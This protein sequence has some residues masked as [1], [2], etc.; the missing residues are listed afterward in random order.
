MASFPI[1][2]LH[3]LLLVA[4]T[5]LALQQPVIAAGQS[6]AWSQGTYIWDSTSL[7]DPQQREGELRELRRAGMTEL[8]VGLSG[9]Q[10]KAGAVT[11]APAQGAD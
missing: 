3:R 1:P 4:L 5:A 9:S 2:P 7:L 10:V 8:M 6:G 11:P